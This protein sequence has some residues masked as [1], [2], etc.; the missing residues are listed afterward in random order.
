M[1]RGQDA[2]PVEWGRAGRGGGAGQQSQAGWGRSWLRGGLRRGLPLAA[3]FSASD[4]ATGRR[5]VTRPA[6][7]TSAWGLAR[8]RAGFGGDWWPRG[9]GGGGSGARGSAEEA[10]CERGRIWGGSSAAEERIEPGRPRA[11][12]GGQLREMI[13]RPVP[14][15]GTSDAALTR[16]SP[17]FRGPWHGSPRRRE[18]AP[19]LPV[20]PLSLTHLPRAGSPHGTSRSG[21]DPPGRRRPVPRQSPR[22]GLALGLPSPRGRDGTRVAPQKGQR[23]PAGA[24]TCFP[25]AESRGSPQ[26]A[27]E[28]ELCGRWA[29]QR[30][31]PLHPSRP[32]QGPGP[33]LLLRCSPSS[34]T[35]LLGDSPAPVL[36]AWACQCESVGVTLVRGEREHQSAANTP[37]RKRKRKGKERGKLRQRV[38]RGVS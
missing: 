38:S 3:Q 13:N 24:G 5:S 35:W 15:M 17:T 29:A 6:D 27:L 12:G 23:S 2:L 9:E 33:A 8:V 1:R 34:T 19:G 14:D 30:R 25:P 16:W 36:P 26:A 11:R 22:P 4:Q 37:E 21:S 10:A 18:S 7:S 31:A 20:C 32:Q 28:R